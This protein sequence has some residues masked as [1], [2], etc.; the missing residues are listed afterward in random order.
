LKDWV[1]ARQRYWG[2]PFPMVFD[3]NHIAY[4]VAD[5]ELPVKL[6]EVEKYE[7]TGTGESPLAGIDSWVNVTGYIDE[8]RFCQLLFR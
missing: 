5:S 1:F 4:A 7:P 3:E 2:E 8:R 6:P